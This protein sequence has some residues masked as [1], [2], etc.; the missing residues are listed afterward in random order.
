MNAEADDV[1]IRGALASRGEL[2]NRGQLAGR[3]ELAGRSELASQNQVTRRAELPRSH[4]LATAAPIATTRALVGSRAGW[5]EPMRTDWPTAVCRRL[6][7]SGVVVRVLVAE[8]L[9]SAPREAGAC[10]LV[11]RE[12]VEGTIGG[13][14][15]EWRA[16]EAARGLLTRDVGQPAARLDRLTLGRELAQCCGGVVQ[17]WIERFTRAD[18][19]ILRRAAVAANGP[20]PSLMATELRAARV[21]RALVRDGEP[22]ADGALAGAEAFSGALS[23]APVARTH[24]GEGQSTDA[25]IG[26]TRGRA[27][28]EGRVR[29]TSTDDGRV[30]LIERIDVARTAVWLYG[31]GHVGQALVRTL[32]ELPFH[33]TWIDSRAD[34]F[35]NTLPDNVTA[36]SAPLD[37]AMSAPR[38][39]R[40]LVMTHDHALDYE[41]CRTI[42]ARNE[43]A[44]LGLIG[45]ESKAA[46]FRSRL[47]RDG[48]ALE[49]IARLVCPIGLTD[50]VSKSPAAIAIGIAAQLLRETGEAESSGQP[51]AVL[52]HHASNPDASCGDLSDRDDSNRIAGNRDTSSGAA[53][54][55]DT[56]SG[57]AGNNDV[58]DRVADDGST[59]DCTA[60]RCSSCQR[61]HR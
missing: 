9:G 1:E 34:I 53:G 45:S 48:I 57:G 42:L 4:A 2:A 37:A 33:V 54:N 10:M 14:N 35:P 31:A 16:I 52:G 27:A 50:I 43:F 7:R 20:G 46:R 13:G 6:E 12:G 21:T 39:A 24:V 23:R 32:A 5:L 41:L 11:T 61:T 58:V 29:L 40:H 38:A 3:G 26:G 59:D 56:S 44:A 51:R 8:V 47:K 49:Q 36:L 28:R 15:L 18:L 55:S 25:R 17:L 30:T 22:C 19:P 60:D